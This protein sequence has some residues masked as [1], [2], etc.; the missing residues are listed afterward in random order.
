MSWYLRNSD[1][2][3]YGPVELDALKEWARQGRIRPD[4]HLSQDRQTWTPAPAL[5]EL[6]MA[7]LID[8]GDGERFGPVHELALAEM[9]REGS[10]P[11]DTL[12]QHV[13]DG[14]ISQLA[15][16]ALPAVLALPPPVAPPDP[17]L[18][19]LRN[20]LKESD[21]RIVELVKQA[22][23]PA[24]DEAPRLRQALTKAE[25]RIAELETKHHAV[26]NLELADGAVDSATLLQSFRELSQNY[27]RLL[28]KLNT[29]SDELTAALAAHARASK[30]LESQVTAAQDNAQKD[31][32]ETEALR[33]RY[34]ELEQAHVEVVRAYRDLNDR[35][36][37]LRQQQADAGGPAATPIPPEKSKIRLV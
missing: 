35:Y 22:A 1:Q 24:D 23:R 3:V 13:T 17:E 20:A 33:V 30:Q 25:E 36:I 14:R 27:D 8:L 19:R 16:I 29:K 15:A 21:A 34:V 11:A 5:A 7:W 32:R 6:G 9:V 12:V 18:A 28:G 31:R 4:D 10:I 37:R 2:A 26:A